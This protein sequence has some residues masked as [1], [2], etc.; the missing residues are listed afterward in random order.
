MHG[1]TSSLIADHLLFTEY[2]DIKG[3]FMNGGAID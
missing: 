1:T 2:D 3:G